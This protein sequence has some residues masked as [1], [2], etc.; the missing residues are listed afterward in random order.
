MLPIKRKQGTPFLLGNMKAKKT[1][2]GSNKVSN[3]PNKRHR[4]KPRHTKVNQFVLCDQELEIEQDKR[5]KRRHAN[6]NKQ[7]Q[8]RIGRVSNQGEGVEQ[9]TSENDVSSQA[10]KETNI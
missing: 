7:Q 2:E 6:W 8:N 10:Q 3:V 9:S 4:R 1:L 5:K